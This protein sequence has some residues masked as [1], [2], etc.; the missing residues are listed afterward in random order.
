MNLLTR[1]QTLRDQ[2]ADPA[3]LRKQLARHLDGG[4]Q[5]SPTAPP[6]RMPV[7]DAYSSAWDAWSGARPPASPVVIERKADKPIVPPK[8]AAVFD[9]HGSWITAQTADLD[10]ALRPII[11]RAQADLQAYLKA[12]LTVQGSSILPSTENQKILDSIDRLYME[13]LYKAGYGE[14]IDNF[15]AGFVG[16]IPFLQA[17]IDYL[18]EAAGHEFPAV[19]FDAADLR[20]LTENASADL[21]STMKAVGS[22]TVGR[23]TS[24]RAAFGLAG[25]PF[26]RMVAIFKDEFGG[27]AKRNAQRAETA[28]T[29]WYRQI[30]EAQYTRIAAALPGL[31]QRYVYLGPN[32]KVTRPFCRRML[33][34]TA[35]KPLSRAQID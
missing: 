33:K 32:D 27:S 10:A 8:L 26:D 14:L 23:I 11:E 34:L 22:S 2:G 19:S 18:A 9:Q 28:I 35:R 15:T 20:V 7:A 30:S 25:L 29:V 6:K 21:V 3:V 17:T 24:E 31:E 12:N 4:S 16:Q 13:F 5:V 1:I